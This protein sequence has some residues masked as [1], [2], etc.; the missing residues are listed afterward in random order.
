MKMAAFQIMW[1]VWQEWTRWN[2]S[3]PVRWKFESN[4]QKFTKLRKVEKTILCNTGV[5][6]RPTRGGTIC[7]TLWPKEGTGKVMITALSFI[8]CFSINRCLQLLCPSPKYPNPQK[9]C[10]IYLTF[11]IAG[12]NSG[13]CSTWRTERQTDAMRPNTSESERLSRRRRW[14]KT[15]DKDKNLDQNKPMCYRLWR[16]STCWRSSQT[17]TSSASLRPSRTLAR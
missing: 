10:P 4:Q 2:A 14:D 11:E 16:R 8:W 13:W 5:A 9:A 6:Y 3:S 15:G 1:E 12:A 17:R 7:T